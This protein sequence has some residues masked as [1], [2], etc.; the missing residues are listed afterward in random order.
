MSISSALYSGVVLAKPVMEARTLYEN[1]GRALAAL[2]CGVAAFVFIMTALVVATMDVVLQL[3]GRGF[4]AWSAMS[5]AA[6]TF[7]IFAAMLGAA[8]VAAFPK[9]P[10]AVKLPVQ[11][12]AQVA[13]QA[14]AQHLPHPSPMG[15]EII[16]EESEVAAEREKIST[17]AR[18]DLDLD[19]MPSPAFTH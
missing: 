10:P 4:V 1:R 2:G 8:A 17:R 15:R 9:A 7:V 6:C 5:T 19:Q 13:L 12:L 18:G 3:D 11:E 16:R 14:L